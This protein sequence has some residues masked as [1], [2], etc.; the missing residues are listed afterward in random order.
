VTL[1]SN[2][3]LTY[4]APSAVPVPAAAWLLGSG[5]LAM[6]GAIRRRKAAAQG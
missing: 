4:V 2:G 6:G 1:A 3:D 5:L